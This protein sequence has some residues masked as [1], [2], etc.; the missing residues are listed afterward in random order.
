[1]QILRILWGENACSLTFTL[2]LFDAF[3]NTHCYGM[4]TTY[5]GIVAFTTDRRLQSFRRTI[6]A[7]TTAAVVASIT[8]PQVVFVFVARNGRQSAD[9][10]RGFGCG[11]M[12]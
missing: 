11:D 4:D 3:V 8:S 7:T 5:I 1:M 6:S 9:K 12:P 2:P 10:L